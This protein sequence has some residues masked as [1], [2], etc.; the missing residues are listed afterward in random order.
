MKILIRLPKCEC[1][2]GFHE[3]GVDVIKRRSE[4]ETNGV[5]MTQMCV[6]YMYG[7]NSAS[8]RAV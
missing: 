7:S 6:G 3:E 5:K 4:C 8:W 2:S 1:K